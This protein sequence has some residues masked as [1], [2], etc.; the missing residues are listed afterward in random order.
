MRLNWDKKGKKFVEAAKLVEDKVY[1]LAEARANNLLEVS[2]EEVSLNTDP[3]KAI[4][5]NGN[6]VEVEMVE[7]T[8]TI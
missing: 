4:D 5:E 8:K 6:E 1:A 7:N 3:I 2:V